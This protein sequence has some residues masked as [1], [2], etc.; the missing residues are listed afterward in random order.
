MTQQPQQRPTG[1]TILA[2]LGI[3]GGVVSLFGGC[4]ALTGGA[5]VG[6][7]GAQAGAG[8]VAAGGGLLSLLGIFTLAMAIGWIA[9]GIGAW[10][11]KPW[12][13]M[14][15]LVLVGVSIVV[16]LVTAV[17]TRDLGGQ[18]IGLAIDAVIVYYLMTPEVKKAFGRA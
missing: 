4:A 5:L 9:F 18:I 16:A 7:F 12:A 2:I 14:L 6:A 8:A 1:I 17:T 10:T 15:G 3:I 11:L 13:W